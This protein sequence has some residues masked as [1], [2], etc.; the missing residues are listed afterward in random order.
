MKLN[1]NF[2][3]LLGVILI[4]TAA[5]FGTNHA[6]VREGMIKVAILYPNEEGKSFDM[7][8]YTTK[9]MPMAAKLF[10]ESMK[11]MVIDKGLAGGGP[12]SPASYAAIGYFYFDDMETC[13]KSMG[14][15]SEALK[16]DVPNYTDI[17]PTVQI[18]E[19]MTAQ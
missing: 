16:A 3:I 13:Q 5:T 10:G 15:H 9:H 2:L 18:S 12:D 1:Q 8:Y 11:A 17:Q 7:E 19:V 14:A 6:E 4:F